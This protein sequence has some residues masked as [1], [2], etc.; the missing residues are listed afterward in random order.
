MLYSYSS[1]CGKT[2]SSPRIQKPYNYYP[3]QHYRISQRYIIVRKTS[4]LFSRYLRQ[5][6]KPTSQI[7]VNWW[8]AEPCQ[9]GAGTYS[10]RKREMKRYIPRRLGHTTGTHNSNE[11]IY[12]PPYS[13]TAERSTKVTPTKRSTNPPRITAVQQMRYTAVVEVE[14]ER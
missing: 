4:C 3:T 13:S 10:G 9:R 2:F 5:I 8:Y 14:R 7:C 11:E 1:V 6:A 12:P